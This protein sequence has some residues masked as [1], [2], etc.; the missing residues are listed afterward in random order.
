MELRKMKMKKKQILALGTVGEE[1]M[2]I[3]DVEINVYS[4]AKKFINGWLEN[5][6][7]AGLP[8]PYCMIC[9]EE[10]LIKE[11]PL[12][13]IATILYNANNKDN[14]LPIQPIVGKCIICKEAANEDGEIEWMP[15]NVVDIIKILNILDVLNIAK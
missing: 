13:I 2:N 5:V 11:L 3:L 6:H 15:L 9:D 1:A 8:S 14:I 7:L 4:E 12:N 10:G